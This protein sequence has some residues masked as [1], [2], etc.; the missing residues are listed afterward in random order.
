[1][2]TPPF[3]LSTSAP[4]DN[5]I[6]SQ[7]P[8]LDRTDKDIIQSYL[9]T[10]HNAATGRH[11]AIGLVDQAGDPAASTQPQ[12]YNN[13]G[14]ITLQTAGGV[15]NRVVLYAAAVK[16]LFP[17]AAVPVGW[18]LDTDVNDR[19]I[20]VNSTAGAGTGGSWDASTSLTIAGHA[21]T[22]NEMPS[23]NHSGA[24]NPGA[25]TSGGGGPNSTNGTTSTGSTGGGASHAHGISSDSVWR[26]SYLDVVKGSL[27]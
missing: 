23:H 13:A 3:S 20:R 1:M 19:M 4:A 11:G 14:L 12:L 26:P 24:A 5:D 2:A 27:N 8:S 16:G 15:K 9:N 25:G 21:L 7:F 17:Q 18:T 22:I 6:V 10:D